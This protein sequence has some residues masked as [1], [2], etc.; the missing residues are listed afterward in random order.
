MS[1]DQDRLPGALG[2]LR[3]IP[4]GTYWCDTGAH[5]GQAHAELEGYLPAADYEILVR[6]ARQNHPD[7]E[8][9][10]ARP[11]SPRSGS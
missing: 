2:R 1:D 6:T 9:G 10:D 4:R 11:G 7:G 8:Q 5:A 3:F